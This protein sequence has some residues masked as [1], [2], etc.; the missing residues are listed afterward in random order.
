MWRIRDVYPGSWIR[1]FSIPDP[2]CLHPGSRILIKEFKYFKPKKAKKLSGLFI[3]DPG[4]GCWLSP[5]PDPG[6]RG[7]KGTQSRIRIRNT[8]Y[9]SCFPL[10]R[11]QWFGT[12]SGFNQVCGSGFGFRRAKITHKNRKKL[13]NFM[14]GSAGCSLL[15]AE[16]FSCTVAWAS[17]MEA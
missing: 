15:R 1:L 13:R 4:S 2:N 12:G 17:F 5:I 14:F 3:P 9:R 16:S 11:Q 8:V 6:S 7:L 10:C